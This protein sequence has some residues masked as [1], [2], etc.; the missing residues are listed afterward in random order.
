MNDD[1]LGTYYF[2]Q[3]MSIKYSRYTG[4]AKVIRLEIMSHSLLRLYTSGININF[5][6]RQSILLQYND[7]NSIIL[8]VRS[9][10]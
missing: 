8:D 9:M 10:V 1:S 2:F 4:I 3:V 7:T 5:K 6:P